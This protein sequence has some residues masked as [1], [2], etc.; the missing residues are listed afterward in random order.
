[1]WQ[2]GNYLEMNITRKDAESVHHSG[3]CELDVKALLAK[4][5]IKRQLNKINPESIQKELR[6]YGAWNE[7]E[8]E[9]LEQ[10]K[11]RLLWLMGG[12]LA[13]RLFLK[14]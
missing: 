4:P 5:Y 10:N 3:D 8:L 11:V 6:Q 13:E 12:D 7:K 14:M 1:M 9:D 2:S